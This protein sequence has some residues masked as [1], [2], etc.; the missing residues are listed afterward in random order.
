MSTCFINNPPRE[1][2]PQGVVDRPVLVR[3]VFTTVPSNRKKQPRS[4]L[5]SSETPVKTEPT[6]DKG[7][8]TDT[9]ASLGS[10]VIRRRLKVSR[11]LRNKTLR[12]LSPEQKKA[13]AKGEYITL[14][15]GSLPRELQQDALAY[16]KQTYPDYR[17]DVASPDYDKWE[18][19]ALRFCPQTSGVWWTTL[20]IMTVSADGHE[21]YF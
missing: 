4:D 8:D 11:V 17:D 13:I 21:Y 20:G 9:V 15:L 16:I 7:N 10:E 1:G 18:S 19:F 6:A 5:I 12:F 2:K 3:R 14:T